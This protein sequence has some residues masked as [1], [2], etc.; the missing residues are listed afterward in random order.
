MRR[1]TIWIAIVSAHALLLLLVLFTKLF[2]DTPLEAFGF[3]LL[4][5]PYLLQQAGLPVLQNNGL[6]DGGWAAP[7]LF[8]WMIAVGVWLA[9]YWFVASVL[10]HLASAWKRAR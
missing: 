6:G 10:A 1:S 9:F 4:A 8:G 3:T 7:N 2:Q 5:V